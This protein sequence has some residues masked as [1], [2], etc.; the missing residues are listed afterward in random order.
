MLSFWGKDYAMHARGIYYRDYFSEDLV[1][2][3]RKVWTP[4]LSISDKQSSDLLTL[5]KRARAFADRSKDNE[6][7]YKSEYA[8]EADA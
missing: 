6:K 4:S 5:Q 2:Y 8:W 1:V 3:N 7:W